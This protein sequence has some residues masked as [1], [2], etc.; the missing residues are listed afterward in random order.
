MT[1]EQIEE[2]R[3]KYGFNKVALVDGE[4]YLPLEEVMKKID[5]IVKERSEK[6]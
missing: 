6:Q 3:E 4:F 1:D 2:F 5:N